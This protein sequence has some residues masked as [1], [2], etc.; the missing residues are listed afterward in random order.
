MTASE[1][2]D[3]SDTHESHDSLDVIALVADLL[4]ASRI[5]G[6]AAA[7]GVR[8]AT[9]SR[10]DAV[11]EAAAEP[12]VRLVLVDLDARSGDATGLIR[13]LKSDDGTSRLPVIAFASHMD[14]AAIRAAQEAG[15]DRVLARSAF[16]RALPGLLRE[17]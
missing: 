2:H 11:R 16:V 17:I 1:P 6:A 14:S 8:V 3:A 5:R 12:G 4:F 13:A 9:A 10:T 7:A 15:A